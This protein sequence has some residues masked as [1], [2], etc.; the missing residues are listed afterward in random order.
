MAEPLELLVELSSLMIEFSMELSSQM[1]LVQLSIELLAL[2][3]GLLVEFPHAVQFLHH[4]PLK[5]EHK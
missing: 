2:G 4:S 5:L 1:I 3:P